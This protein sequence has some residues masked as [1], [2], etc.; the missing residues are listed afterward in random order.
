MRTTQAIFLCLQLN[1]LLAHLFNRTVAML[2]I[3]CDKSDSYVFNSHV[4]RKYYSDLCDE[5]E[6]LKHLKG[7]WTKKLDDLKVLKKKASLC[8]LR[9]TY[10]KKKKKKKK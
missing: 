4:S 10:P 9:L 1:F 3:N 8:P 5:R 7:I 6:F 2:Y